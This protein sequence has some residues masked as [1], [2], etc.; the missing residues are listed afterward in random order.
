MV[1]RTPFAKTP[2]MVSTTTVT[3]ADQGQRL[4]RVTRVLFATVWLVPAAMAVAQVVIVEHL[5]GR[6]FRVLDVLLW[7]G[8]AW[9][10]WGLWS[11]VILTM[12]DRVPLRAGHLPVWLTK[13][14]VVCIVICTLTVL[15]LGAL[16]YTFALWRTQPSY[17]KVVRSVVLNHL[18]FQFVLYW[19]VLGA[20]YMVEYLRRY[21][22]RDRVALELE[23]KLA[24]TQLE[25]LRMQLNPHFLFNALNSVAELM[26]MDVREAQHMLTRVSDLLRLSLR[27]A[28][29]ATIPLWQEVELI[30]LYLQIARV[31]FGDKL[32]V[33]ITVDPAAVDLEVPSFVLQPLVENALKH[34]LSPHNVGQSVDVSARRMGNT[35][36]LIVEDNGRGLDGSMTNSGR[37]LA[38]R[39]NVDGLGIGLTNTR[40][41]LKMLF[42]ERYLF[43]MHNTAT[44][45]CRVEIRL[46]LD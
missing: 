30:E 34:G 21:R 29:T 31:R 40:S 25:A 7:Q 12:V 20:A 28:A 41:R 6:P 24:Q 33:D 32:A 13:H 4:R 37:F 22:E 19:A 26:E 11:Q 38:A 2:R 23:Q 27:S 43:R 16:D 14:L 46:P 35:L 15:A 3:I 39:P 10:L 1:A 5:A 45:G 42:G 9:G 36:E 44:G 18:D 8:G 17:A